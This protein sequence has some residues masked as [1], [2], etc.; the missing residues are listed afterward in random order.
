MLTARYGGNDL[1]SLLQAAA[2]GKAAPFPPA[3]DRGAWERVTAESRE[4]WIGKAEACLAYDWP[5]LQAQT[6]IEVKRTGHFNPYIDPY[7]KR[8]ETL[9]SL[10]LGECIEDGGRFTLAIVTGIM[11]ICEETTWLPPHMNSYLTRVNKAETLHAAADHEVELF[12]S[13]TAALLAWTYD[14]LRGK[15]DAISGRI[16]ERIER[17]VRDR[18]IAPYLAR[19]DYWWMGFAGDRVNNWNPWCNGNMLMALAVFERDP[20]RL[21]EAVGKIMRSL[22]VFIATYP[23]DGCCD[24]GPMYWGRSGASLYD[25]LELLHLMSGG[26]IDIYAETI[27]REIGRYIVKAHIHGD[28]YV[29]FADGDAI[30]F[31]D[32]DAI[33]GYGLAIGDEGM[34]RLG[35]GI[36]VKRHGFVDWF[37]LHR[38][39]RA[40]LREGER[41][42]RAQQPP[43][44]RDVWFP[45]SQVM[46]AREA[47]GTA[48]G[49]YVAAKGGHNLESH[50]H[51]D[52]GNFIV[53]ADGQ[54]VFIDLG[55][56]E[57]RAQTFG[58]QRFELWYLQS[59]YHNVPTVNGTMQRDGRAFAAQGAVRRADDDE[60]DLSLDIAAAYPAE[61]GIA[62]WRRTFRLLRGANAAVE[63]V[64]AFRLHEPGA[65]VYSLMTPLKPKPLDEGVFELAYAPGRRVYVAYD[66]GRLRM[67]AERVAID[68]GRLRR[69]WGDAVYRIMLESAEPQQAETHV[70]RVAMTA[71][72]AR[73]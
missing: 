5:A 20:L 52:I 7:W 39:A 27:V 58:P 70:L 30:V 26:A 69:N 54:P 36:P 44:M 29:D 41:R 28:Y 19:D 8:R 24:E 15:L 35:A 63:I 48:R 25:C 71:D 68:D 11:C 46:A 47:E 12:S 16:G 61:A 67:R 23:A 55:T 6:Y 10:V 64:D 31:A 4:E 72:A 18:L 13:E 34:I 43:Y 38:H 50:N 59:Q 21:A 60:S 73:L 42:Q 62:C 33:Y 32:G 45:H 66:A 22:D 56:E 2:A 37:P 65:V 49:L 9:G 40:L 51:N 57:Y 1:A 3:D 14:L 17:E 53:Y